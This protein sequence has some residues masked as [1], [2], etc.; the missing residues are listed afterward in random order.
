MLL[1]IS[2]GSAKIVFTSLL[3]KE[4]EFLKRLQS[5]HGENEIFVLWHGKSSGGVLNLDII[6][7][8]GSDVVGVLLGQALVGLRVGDSDQL[9]GIVNDSVGNLGH[10]SLSMIVSFVLG[11][12]NAEGH[13]V[14]NLLQVGSD[15]SEESG[16]WVLFNLS[17]LGS[18]TL[19]S[20]N[21]SL[22]DEIGSDVGKSFK[23][24]NIW[25]M[26]SAYSGSSSNKSSI[27]QEFHY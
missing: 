23:E 7:D 25:D 9:V 17:S 19:L 16:L 11:I 26:S 21:F 15:G 12:R 18:G 22:S 13:I 27:I 20:G 10:K 2:K 3:F 8:H 5:V 4:I 14:V 6:E 24:S 1:G